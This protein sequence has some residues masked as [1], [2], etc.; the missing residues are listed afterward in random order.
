MKFFNG[1]RTA[2]LAGLT[3]VALLAASPAAEAHGWHRRGP[4]GGAVAAGIIG[5]LAVGALVAGA[6]QA[7]PPPPPV[8]YAPPPPPVYYAPPVA[9]YAPPPPPRAYYAPPR[10][11]CITRRLRRRRAITPGR[12]A[13]FE[14]PLGSPSRGVALRLR[15]LFS[16]GQDP[17]R[18]MQ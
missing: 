12:Q 6:A 4:S 11:A 15:R 2:A 17:G 7:A 3:G 8:Y 14:T 13:K 18:P 5:G 1:L 9:Y 10:P 16:M